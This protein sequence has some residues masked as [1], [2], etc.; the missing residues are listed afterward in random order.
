MTS[1]LKL[2][3]PR[4]LQ[5]LGSQMLQLLQTRLWLKILVGLVLGVGFGI[6]LGPTSHLVSPKTADIIVSWAALP[7]QIFLALLQMIVV[8]LVFASIIRGLASSEDIE[9]LRKVGARLA[10]YFVSTT[11]VAI[12][13]GLFAAWLIRPGK[14]VDVTQMPAAGSGVPS[15]SSPAQAA[16]PTLERAPQ[17]LTSLIPSNP[18]EAM[19][20][21]QMLQI[22]LFAVIVGVALVSLRAADAKPILDLLGSL[23]RVCM[24]V[25]NWTMRLA[26]IAVV[27]LMMR[28]ISQLGIGALIGLAAYVATVLLGLA[29]LLMLYLLVVTLVTRQSPLHFVRS[30]RDVQLLAFSTSSSAAAMPLS[31]QTAEERLSVR[32]SIAQLIV[33]LG[34]TI[35]MDGTALYQGVATM[36]LAQIFGVEL[37]IGQLALVTLTAVLASVGAP[38]TPGAGIVILGLVLQSVGIPTEGIALIIGVDRLLDMCRSAVNVTGD[39][40][41]CIVMDRWVGGKR[42][43][44]EERADEAALEARRTA[45]GE[46]VIMVGAQ[47]RD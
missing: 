20:Q 46:D 38:S 22:V 10:L 31:I 40:T 16:A 13:I 43:V 25:V 3:K 11:S 47:Q 24:T 27:G 19:V 14:L 32:P 7:G 36:F 26:P 23:Q 42:T 6:L 9:Q 45:S 41:A 18:L 5:H 4:S 17:L 30:V 37:G 35:N 33:P 8:P 39:L 44:E 29:V 1:P 15:A 2:L 12:T 28:V 21:G 34:S